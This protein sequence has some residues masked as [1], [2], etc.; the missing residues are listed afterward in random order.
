MRVAVVAM[1][2]IGLPLAVQFASS[3]HDVIGVDVNE[4]TVDLINQ[5]KEPFPGEAHLQEKLSELVPAGKLRAT[6]NYADAIPNAD[7]IVL[8]VP[9]FVNDETWQPDFGWMDQATRSLAEHLTP[10]TL[11][12]YETTLPVGTTRNRWKPLIEEISG[13]KEGKDFHLVFS[14]ERVLTGRVFQDLR[15]YPKLVGGL[16]EAGTQ[17]AIKFYESVLQFDER[18]D[19]PRE[20]GVWDMGNAEAA[21]MAKLA[22]TTYRDVNIGLANQFAV[23]ADKVG[24]DVQKVIDACNSQPYSHIHRPGIAVGG[25]CIPVYP[26]LYL[27]TDPDAS[28]VRTAR[29]YNAGMPEYVVSRVEEVLGDLKDVKVAVL[30]ASYRGAVKETAFSGVFATVDSLRKRGAKVLVH[31]PMFS[32]EELAGFGWDA[33]HLGEEVTAAI[34]QADHAEYKTI[35]AKDLPDIKLLFD[36]RR[37]TDP[38]LWKGTPRMVIG[39]QASR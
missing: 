7:A 16:S 20:N 19:L 15:R 30:G 28:V 38:Q 39:D 12:S 6:T 25:H 11:I 29:T 34:V 24:I 5:A 1:G 32:D 21:E 36:G 31:D 14:P 33:Y 35:S 3:G 26:R 4:K 27:S 37:V 9:L 10:G 17:E 22:E 8:V 13:L 23:Y 18:P 2:K